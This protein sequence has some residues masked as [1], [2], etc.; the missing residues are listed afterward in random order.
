MTGHQL[1]HR[2][3]QLIRRSVQVAAVL[4][5]VMLIF[6]G[7]YY[8]YHASRSLA[9]IESL[10][11]WRGRI[12]VRIDDQ[13]RNIEDPQAFVKDNN[14]NLWSMRLRGVDIADPLAF[15]EATAATRS[16]HAPLLVSILIPILATC[17]LGR[18]FCSWICPGYLIF[19][20]A[21][22]LR[23]IFTRVGVEPARI[24]FS[25]TNKYILLG[26][27]L[28]I[29]AATSLPIFSLFY[30][31]ALLSRTAHAVVFGTGVT[32]MLTL[33]CSLVAFEVFIS[34]R[35]WCRTMCPGGALYG[36][37]GSRR[38]LRVQLVPGRCTNC[39]LCEPVCEAGLDPITESAGIECDNCG[40][41][42]RHC[43]EQALAFALGLSA[44]LGTNQRGELQRFT[45]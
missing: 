41:C 11:G 7:L 29:A 16:V 1:K 9:D 12:L 2:G 30:P 23:T 39:R 31:P 44:G 24:T 26:V 33:T 32:G 36:L 27:G 14:G 25:H 4:L 43:P 5:V 20:L 3:I 19:E 42:I 34:P 22:K 28:V 40:V 6:L 15:A 17:F 21:G 37:I 45:E 10:P 35:W 8:N 38:A 13:M 18:V